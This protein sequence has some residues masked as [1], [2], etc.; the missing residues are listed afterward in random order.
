MECK[1][2]VVNNGINCQPQLVIAGF[3]VAINSSC[4]NNGP[5]IP[6]KDG[7]EGGDAFEFEKSCTGG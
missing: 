7:I 2:P 6:I 3:L 1:K 5:F 4:Q